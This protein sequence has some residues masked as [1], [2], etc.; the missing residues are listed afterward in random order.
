MYVRAGSRGA[1]STDSHVQNASRAGELPNLQAEGSWWPGFLPVGKKLRMDGSLSHS[2]ILQR[3][4]WTLRHATGIASTIDLPSNRDAA[5]CTSR[6]LRAIGRNAATHPRLW[7]ANT[8]SWR[9]TCDILSQP[10]F[11][12]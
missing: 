8:P 6:G 9:L 2:R 12:C 7:G 10:T 4:H 11:S 1:N 3:T 5:S